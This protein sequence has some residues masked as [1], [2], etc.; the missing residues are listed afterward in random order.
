MSWQDT[1]LPALRFWIQDIDPAAYTWSDIQ[2]QTFL[3]VAAR[4]VF[5]DLSGWDGFI[6]G[7]YTVTI[8]PATISPDPTW[9]GAPLAIGELIVV[10]AACLITTGEYKQLGRTA[11]WKITDNK[12]TIDGSQAVGSA[13][14]TMT[15]FCSQYSS[16]L[17]LFKAGNQSIGRAI[18]SPFANANGSNNITYRAP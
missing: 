13:K 5:A 17:Q 15:S 4:S 12:S 3:A 11:G 1:L 16:G 18:L 2:L 14:D 6:G 10:K 8:V 9:S 7:P